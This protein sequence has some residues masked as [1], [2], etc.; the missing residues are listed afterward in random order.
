[1]NGQ[2]AD[3]PLIEVI[4]EIQDRRLRGV[5][6]LERKP[7]KFYVYFADGQ[8]IFAISN[9][10]AHRL[11]VCLPEWKSVSPEQL[12]AAQKHAA[13][14]LELMSFLVISATLTRDAMNDALMRRTAEIVR[15][16]LLWPDGEWS[17]EPQVKPAQE[18]HPPINAGELFVERARRLPPDVI[19]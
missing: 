9:L 7:V 16:S 12:A 17:F 8:I 10:R 14:E 6:R 15:T 1:M 4:R 3:H 5:L 2:I 19:T 18:A 13:S 11:D